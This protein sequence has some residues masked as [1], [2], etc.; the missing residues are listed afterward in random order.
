MN[1]HIPRRQILEPVIELEKVSF[2]YNGR[3]VLTQVDLKVA[4]RDF[5][6]V[7]GPNGGGKTTLLRIILGLLKPQSGQVRIM[8]QPPERRRRV[9]GYMP[10][11]AQVDLN[12]P[13]SVLEVVLMGRLG[14]VGLRA[15][16]SRA[17]RAAA[18]QALEQVEMSDLAGRRFGSLSGGQRQRALIARALAGDPAILLLD[19]PTANVDPAGEREI[20][21]ILHQLNQEHTI[22][23]VSH[24]LGFVSPHVGH[25]ICVNRRGGV[26]THPTAQITP[27]LIN[28]IYGR[29]MHIVRHDHQ[30]P[31]QG[32]ACD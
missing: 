15:R 6:A 22:L 20:F 32:C 25:V 16:Y 10:Q 3:Q 30:G 23:V 18:I 17:D 4:A 5:A 9:L 21:D 24:D 28:A 8:G 12:F 31:P 1:E 14:G 29:T 26:V 7:V 11:Y 13:V 27:E 2:A 19:E